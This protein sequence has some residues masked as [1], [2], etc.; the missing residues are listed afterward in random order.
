MDSR[1]VRARRS[2]RA[3]HRPG[4][5]DRQRGDHRRP[6]QQEHRLFE[7]RVVGESC[8][9]RIEKHHRAPLHR[10]IARLAE[11]M[12]H[13]RNHRRPQAREH[14]R[15]QEHR[16]PSARTLSPYAGRGQGEGS[17]HITRG[18]GERSAPKPSPQPSPGVP[19]EGEE[20]APITSM[21]SHTSTRLRRKVV[22]V[23]INGLSVVKVANSAQGAE[24]FLQLALMRGNYLDRF[25]ARARS[26]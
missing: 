20:G 21:R 18:A 17:A 19:G 13:Q 14:D 1:L 22:N 11:Q 7:A 2:P 12:Q 9:L 4:Q 25:A 15:F 23:S 6:Q 16:P 10:A 26:R 24:R 3:K 8:A 5:G